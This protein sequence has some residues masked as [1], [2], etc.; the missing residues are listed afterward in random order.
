MLTSF[1][2]VQVWDCFLQVPCSL[3]LFAPHISASPPTFTAAKGQNILT[4]GSVVGLEARGLEGERGRRKWETSVMRSIQAHP[5]RV[6]TQPGSSLPECTHST[7]PPLATTTLPTALRWRS[8]RH[9]KANTIC[10]SVG[11]QGRESER[12]LSGRRAGGLLYESTCV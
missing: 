2:K 4:G 6:W 11:R 5:G 9:K 1:L 7:L 3:F 8:N 10:L 12:A